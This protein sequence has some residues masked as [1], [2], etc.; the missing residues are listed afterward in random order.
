MAFPN[1]FSAVAA[2]PFYV[3]AAFT[4]RRWRDTGHLENMEALCLAFFG[5]DQPDD[6]HHHHRGCQGWH[7]P[8]VHFGN[9]AGA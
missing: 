1:K 5:S 6:L 8:H 2:L 4:Y 3:S 7:A 9:D